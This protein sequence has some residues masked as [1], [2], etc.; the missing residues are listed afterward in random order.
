MD[1]GFEGV[2]ELLDES[3]GLKNVDDAD[4]EQQALPLV[5]PGRDATRRHSTRDVHR[6]TGRLV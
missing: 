2:L 1:H 5:V 3:V 4:E 6:V